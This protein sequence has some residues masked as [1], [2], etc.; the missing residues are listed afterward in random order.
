MDT[1]FICEELAARI[2]ILEGYEVEDSGKVVWNSRTG[3]LK[4]TLTPE[5]ENTFSV[6]FEF[7]QTGTEKFNSLSSAYE[8]ISSAEKHFNR[9]LLA[10]NSSL[11]GQHGHYIQEVH[12]ELTSPWISEEIAET[13]DSIETVLNQLMRVST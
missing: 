13:K 9:N 12:I 10:K 7:I 4:T 1:R 11:T 5:L 3:R 2:D 6:K 8:I